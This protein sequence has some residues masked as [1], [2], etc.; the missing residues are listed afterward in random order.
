MDG[1]VLELRN[2]I[3]QS[4]YT[5]AITG[6]GISVSAGIG[7]FQRMNFPVVLQMS[8]R[9]ILENFPNYYYKLARKAFLDPM[10]CNGATIAHI[11]LAELERNGLLQGI[12][13]TNIDC[14][15][16]L[17][18][19]K[20]VAEIQ[21]SFGINKCLKCGK[22][23]DNVY[24][25]NEGKIPRCTEC[26]GIIGAFP[27]YKHIGLINSE[28]YKARNWIRQAELIL[29]IGARESYGSVYY[30]YISQNTKIIQINI[31]Q[32]QFDNISHLNIYKSADEVF[33]QL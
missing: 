30:D 15:H 19:S 25:W 1:Y 31:S 7:D 27:I 14:L 17:A 32:T 21:G 6:A 13:T 33:K 3:K 23:Y 28:V 29:I 18:G 8:S 12:I 11:K 20:N 26:G 22:H 4:H 16:S 24:I 5:V 9:T 10:F 2:F